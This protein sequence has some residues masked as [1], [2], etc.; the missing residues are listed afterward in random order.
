MHIFT[1]VR[2]KLPF[3][4]I[5]S[6]ILFH[7]VNGQTSTNIKQLY[8]DIFTSHQKSVIPNFNFSQPLEITVKLFLLTITRFDEVDETLDTGVAIQTTWNDDGIS[9]KP[10]S[11]GNAESIVVPHTDIWTPKL[12]LLNSIETYEPLGGDNDLLGT[13]RHNGS[14]T[15]IVGDVLSSKCTPN[16]YK[17]PFDSQTCQ[18]LFVVWGSTINDIHLKADP[19]PVDINFFKPNSDWTLQSYQGETYL[20][21]GYDVFEISLTIKRAPLYYNIVV[22]CPTILFGLS[23]PLVFLLP[24]ESGERVGLSI[25]VLLSYAIF[26]TI[27]QMAVPASSNPMSLLLVFMIV[28]IAL[29]GIIV[30]VA[31]YISSLYYRDPQSKMNNILK[32]IG[33]RRHGIKRLIAVDP[34]SETIEKGNVKYSTE[35]NITWKDVCDELDT[36]MMVISYCIIT[37][38]ICLYFIIVSV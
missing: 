22:S 5:L 10:S 16:I 26:L 24:V 36:C 8:T 14:S 35:M 15:I 25:T 33:S 31:I 2:F 7:V 17:F 1:A 32:Y 27:V 19:D 23:N 38:I 29:S 6:C 20:W 30:A 18:L 3:I 34:E 28:T 11:Y 21:H 12:V 37:F 13:V 4:F 9:W